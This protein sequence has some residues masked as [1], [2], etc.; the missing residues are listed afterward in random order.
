MQLNF[1]AIILST[2]KYGENSGI[3]CVLTEEHGIYK[4]L[5]RGITGARQRGI[6]QPGN[7]I[8]ATWRARLSEH[9]GNLSAGLIHPGAMP[10]MDNPLKLAALCSL[11]S[12]IEIS[13]QERDPAPTIYK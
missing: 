13:L 5:V 3:A 11:C 7:F 12:T 9:L 4:G 1:E 10:I 2:A 6:Y 8:E